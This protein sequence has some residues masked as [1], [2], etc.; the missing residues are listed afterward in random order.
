MPAAATDTQ[1]VLGVSPAI[2][3]VERMLLRLARV[4]T[5]VLFT[6]LTYV[7]AWACEWSSVHNGFPFGL[8]DDIVYDEWSAILD[9]GDVLVFHSDGLSEAFLQSV[10][11]VTP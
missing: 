3:A 6:V 5:T 1:S 8:Y 10:R 11:T 2:N 9:P 7:V 4:R